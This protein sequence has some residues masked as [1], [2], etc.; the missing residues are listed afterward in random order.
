MEYKKLKQMSKPNQK[1]RYRELSSG[2]QRGRG[3]GR[4]RWMKGTNSMVTDGN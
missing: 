2:S 3:R 4:V 1:H